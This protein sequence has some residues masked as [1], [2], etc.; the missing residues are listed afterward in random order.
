VTRRVSMT[1]LAD[2]LNVAGYILATSVQPAHVPR[3]AK[4]MRAAA[5]HVMGARF[6]LAFAHALRAVEYH[7]TQSI[8]RSI[9]HALLPL[10][11]PR[12]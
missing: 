1:G 8:D 10:F 12:C 5:V 4:R 3:S 2:G 6:P 11:V 9:G 7:L